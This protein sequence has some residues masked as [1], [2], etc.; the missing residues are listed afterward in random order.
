MLRLKVSQ[1]LAEFAAIR[2]EK[3]GII[4][5]RDM[6]VGKNTSQPTNVRPGQ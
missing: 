1:S 3:I 6:R 4:F 5:A 2:R